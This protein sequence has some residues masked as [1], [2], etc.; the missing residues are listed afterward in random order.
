MINKPNRSVPYLLRTLGTAVTVALLASCATPQSGVRPQSVPA[1]DYKALERGSRAEGPAIVA[2]AY[3]S[4]SRIPLNA[5]SMGDDGIYKSIIIQSLN[6][7]RSATGTVKVMAR[8]MNC[9]ESPLQVRMRTSFLRG[10][11]ESAMPSEPVS[12]WRTVFFQPRSL[13]VYEELSMSREVD[14]FLIEVGR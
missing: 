8:F 14:Y 3:D 11:A 4:V 7:E 6:S 9:T 13:T 12:A 10:P 5:V 2:L 1:C